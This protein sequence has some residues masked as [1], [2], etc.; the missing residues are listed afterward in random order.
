MLS[1]A[2]FQQHLASVDNQTTVQ[3]IIIRQQMKRMESVAGQEN[4][5][6]IY[7]R[8]GDKNLLKKAKETA[9]A[10]TD[11]HRQLSTD[12]AADNQPKTAARLLDQA[13]TLHPLPD[14]KRRIDELRSTLVIK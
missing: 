2:S 13:G 8:E 12:W 6:A 7:Q 11:S 5:K 4:D 9:K 3:D 14:V 1:K 10:L